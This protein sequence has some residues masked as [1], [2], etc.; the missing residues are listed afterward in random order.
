MR[1][2]GRTYRVAE[3]AGPIGYELLPGRKPR[4]LSDEQRPDCS[5]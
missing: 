1:V 3:S 5:T 4:R 2:N